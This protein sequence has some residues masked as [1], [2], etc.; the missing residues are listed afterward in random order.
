MTKNK[1]NPLT[2]FKR[3]PHVS[4]LRLYGAIGTGGRFSQTLS[5]APLEDAIEAAFAS[6]R[7]KAVALVINSPGGSP[8]QSG[9]IARHIRRLADEK[10]I[11][12][13]A[14]CEDAAASGG[15]LLACAA[16]EIFVDEYTV[17]GSVGVISAS[18]GAVEAIGKLGIERRLHTAGNSKALMDP[19]SPKKPEDEERLKTILTAIHE[20]FIAWVKGS[21]GARLKDGVDYFQGDVW[22]GQNAVD[23]GVADGV[24]HLKD[25][26]KARYGKTMRLREFGRRK[27]SLLGRLAGKGANASLTSMAADSVGAGAVTAL[28]ETAEERALWARYGL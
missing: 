4:V 13:L 14:F 11:P 21:R 8:A 22:I 15:Y 2:W 3:G 9:L 6:K 7:T 5:H 28:V 1:W 25:I 16:D 19:F 17:I 12:V 10:N 26:I 23:L 27:A 20:R 18:F 24:G